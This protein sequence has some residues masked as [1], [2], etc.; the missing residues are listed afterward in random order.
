MPLKPSS[1]AEFKHT[2]VLSSRLRS[3]KG[4]GGNCNRATEH[5]QYWMQTVISVHHFSVP[6][7]RQRMLLSRWPMPQRTLPTS[8]QPSRIDSERIQ[9]AWSGGSEEENEVRGR[10]QPSPRGP[11]AHPALGQQVSWGVPGISLGPVSCRAPEP[12]ARPT[13]RL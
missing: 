11:P 3:I 9:T 8:N 2:P 1:S 13:H 4:K 6:C 7:T 10:S 12:S 5:I